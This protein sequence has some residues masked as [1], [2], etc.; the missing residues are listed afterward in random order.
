[1]HRIEAERLSSGSPIL[2]IV[3][4]V[5]MLR[6]IYVSDNQPMMVLDDSLHEAIEQLFA[7]TTVNID[8]QSI[9]NLI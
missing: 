1:M 6:G 9:N 5:Y 7:K 8:L 2:Q 3:N 4:G